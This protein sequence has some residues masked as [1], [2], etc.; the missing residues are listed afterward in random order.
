M[1]PEYKI[2]VGADHRGFQ[3]KAE[4]LPILEGCHP[5]VKVVDM[6]AKEYKE[7]DDFNDPAI[8]V[9]LAVLGQ[10]HSFGVLICGSAHGVTMQANRIRGIRAINCLTPESAVIGKQDDYANVLCL[11]ADALSVAEMDEII[12]AFC[13]TAPKTD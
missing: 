3:K 4:L 13:H 8:D 10:E 7:D 9:S 1:L 6:G 5:N 2:Y 11:S 12:K